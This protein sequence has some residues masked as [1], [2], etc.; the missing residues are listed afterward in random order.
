MNIKRRSKKFLF[1]TTAITAIALASV[2]TVSAAVI[3]G[4]FTGGDV[5]V[6]GVTSGTIAYGT[7]LDGSGGWTPTLTVSSGSW[8]TQLHV[9]TGYVGPVTI[10]WQLESYSSGTWTEVGD[11]TV[12]D[13]DLSGSTVNIY[14]TDDGAISNN[15]DWSIDANSPAT[16][17][18]TVQIESISA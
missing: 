3:L 4:T 2:L 16:Y 6:T 5:T 7:T 8:Y 11:P 15:R 9:D 18:V 12:T 10:T 14:A 17:R 1:I 13:F